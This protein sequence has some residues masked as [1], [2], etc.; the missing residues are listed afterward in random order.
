MIEQLMEI[1][2]GLRGSGRSSCHALLAR[3]CCTLNA[4]GVEKSS[5]QKFV[6]GSVK[7]CPCDDDQLKEKQQSTAGRQTLDMICMCLLICYSLS[8]SV[9]SIYISFYE[10]LHP[11][12]LAQD[13]VCVWGGWFTR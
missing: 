8:S 10:C 12:A 9:Y 7:P 3:L 2:H 6:C 11:T 13:R 4:D 1:K 5:E